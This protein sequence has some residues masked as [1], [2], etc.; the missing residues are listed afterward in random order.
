MIKKILSYL[1][2]IPIEIIPSNISEQLELTWN[3]G[4]LV[5]DTKRTNY[6]YG[7]LQKVLRKGLLKIGKQNIK[8]MQHILI[9]GVAGGSVV[10][11]LTDE[12]MFDKK[13]TGIEIDPVVIKVAKKYFK[14][15]DIPNFEIIIA[16][17]N[18]Y[19]TET[20]QIYDLIIIDLFEDC[21]MPDFVYSENFVSNIKRSLKPKGFILFN[22]IVIDKIT[23]EKNKSY[24]NQFES[25]KFAIQKFPNIDDQNELFII[26]KEYE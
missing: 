16:D 5:L 2:P 7:N 12:F 4:K 6:S 8:Q 23:E 21:F 18:K 13:I 15:H 25:T 10:K 3:N 20:K 19:I 22:T 11:T 17:A 9:L 26:E 14:I 1:V 24:I